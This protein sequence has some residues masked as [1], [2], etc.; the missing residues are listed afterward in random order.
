V[1]N[2][3]DKSE[4]IL[5]ALQYEKQMLN[6]HIIKVLCQMDRTCGF[7]NDEDEANREL[8]TGL[9][10]LGYNAQYHYNVTDRRT[11]DIFVDDTIIE[12]KLDPNTSDVDRLI[13]QITDYMNL[14]HR[15]FIVLYGQVS[16]Q[17]LE[18]IRNFAS[19][20]SDKVQLVYLSEANRMRRIPNQT[21]LVYR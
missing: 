4:L 17:V 2:K 20:H 1:E 3:P 6:G 7:Y 9:S 5:Q 19:L 15:I 8:T 13:G 14:P 11:V 16:G 21:N 18:R 10:L 12:G